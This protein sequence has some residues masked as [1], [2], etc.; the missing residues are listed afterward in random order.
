VALNCAAIPENLQESELFGHEK[1]AFTGADHA[2]PGRFELADKGTLFLD[3]VGDLSLLAQAKLLRVLQGE[4][5]ERVGGTKSIRVDV[6]VVT[7]TNQDL[8]KATTER[9]FREDLLY[10]IH[11]FPIELPPLRERPEDIPLLVERFIARYALEMKK[12]VKGIDS[13]A[14]GMLQRYGWP[15]NVRELQNCMERAVILCPR[16]EIQ[17]PHIQLGLER[18]ED[19]LSIPSGFSGSLHEASSRACRAVEKKLI[20]EALRLCKGNKWQ[21]AK[22]LHVSY[23]TLLFKIKDLE[24]EQ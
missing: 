14:L 18:E 21:T 7:A 2:K 1:G 23:K 8:V 17:A 16:E 11:V 4:S 3:E 9:R 13:E 6:R 12:P 10:R 22:R 15:G 24:I 19:L 5:F 20:K